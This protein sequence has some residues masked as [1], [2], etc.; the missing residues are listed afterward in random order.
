MSSVAV[1]CPSP[2][3]TVMVEHDRPGDPELHLHGGGQRFW[4]AR[5]IA[6]L[7]VKAVLCAPIGGEVGAVLRAVIESQHIELH[8]VATHR[9]N[10]AYVHER[11]E[12]QRVAVAETSS[13]PLSRHETDE[14]YGAI[15]AAAMTSAITALTGPRSP[16][17]IDLD[18]YRRLA[19]DLRNNGRRVVAD[20]SG[21]ALDSALAGGF[22]LLKLSAEELTDAVGCGPDDPDG[23]VAAIQ[24]LRARGAD[25]VVLTRGP[26]PALVVLDDEVLEI[27]VPVF[28]ARDPHG[29]GDAMFAAVCAEFALGRDIRRALRTGAAAGA[30]NATRAG[31]GTGNRP[32]IER[33][34][35]AVEIAPWSASA[36]A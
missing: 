19:T 10:G 12:G 9:S 23:Q 20:L 8:A 21:G 1:F 32:D 25:I 4:V 17:V 27:R 35:S 14:L 18:I 31:L 2:I 28:E 36:C 13:P 7:D 11:R 15:A 3:L 29:T 26:A 6:A 22:D 16:G 5:M 24:N 30:L 34:A 33:L